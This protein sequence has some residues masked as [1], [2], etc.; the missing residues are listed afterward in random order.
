MTRKSQTSHS[1]SQVLEKI[2]K[3]LGAPARSPEYVVTATANLLERKALADRR[4]T[5]AEHELEVLRTWVA[6]DYERLRA[7]LINGVGQAVTQNPRPI[8]GQAPGPAHRNQVLRL[9]QVVAQT[10]LSRSTIYA[11]IKDRT[12]PTP[13][14]LG[15]RSVGWLASDIDRWLDTILRSGESGLP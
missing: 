14:K 11:R 3:L 8:P 15:G 5:I 4:A 7:L 10:G 9:R 1:E 2:A 12:F 13:V 6:G